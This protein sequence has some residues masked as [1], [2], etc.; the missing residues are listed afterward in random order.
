M[1]RD[2]RAIDTEVQSGGNTQSATVRVH[3]ADCCHTGTRP[4][5]VQLRRHDPLCPFPDWSADACAQCNLI[6]AVREDER[7]RAWNRGQG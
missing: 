3:A 6:V 5:G 2:L 7:E 1:I 4:A